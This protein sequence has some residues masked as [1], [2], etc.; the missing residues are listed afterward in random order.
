MLKYI[1]PLIP[2]HKLYTESFCGGCAV[3]F[4]KRPV[5]CEVINDVNRG[6]VNFYLV[7]KRHYDMLKYEIESTLHCRDQHAHARHITEY[8]DF[9]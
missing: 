7:A 5:D 9:F 8:P 2:E 1:L 4:A 6:L 3:L